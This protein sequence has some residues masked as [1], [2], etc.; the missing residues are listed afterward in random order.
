MNIRITNKLC[1]AALAA[2]LATGCASQSRTISNSGYSEYGNS[3]RNAERELTELDVLGIDPTAAVSEEEIAAASDGARQVRLKPGSKIMLVQSGAQYPDAPMVAG[4]EKQFTVIPFTGF[5]NA[6]ASQ[7]ADGMA[8]I[9]RR[10]ERMRNVAIVTDPDKPVTI[11]PMTSDKTDDSKPA[12]E[13]RKTAYSR[14]LRLAAARSGASTIIC[15]W[16]ILE[17]GNEKIPTKMVSWLPGVGWV[18]PDE[19]EH[20]R[21]R[22]KMA[23]ID[24]RSGNWTE[25]SPR[26]FDTSSFSFSPRREVADQ[27]QV[28]SLKTKIY[29]ASVEQLTK[30]YVD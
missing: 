30:Q 12:A 10:S 22:V 26:A 8:N 19:R 20:M 13:R 27:K 29:Q 24:V 2:L 9:G 3:V 1:L 25:F 21:I 15:Y 16:G 5:A 7:A 4:L 6:V 28:E 17:S 14:L 18:L 11:V 23:V